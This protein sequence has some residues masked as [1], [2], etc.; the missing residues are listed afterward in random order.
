MEPVLIEACGLTIHAKNPMR[1]KKANKVNCDLIMLKDQE[2]MDDWEKRVRNRK[3]KRVLEVGINK[4]GSIPYIFD[5]LQA[6]FIVGVDIIEPVPG[7][8]KK[9]DGSRLN[10]KYALYFDTDQTDRAALNGICERHFKAGLDL[11]IDDASHLLHHTR[12]SFEI[13]FPKLRPGGL[14][15]IEDYVWAH[16]AG[17][18]MLAPKRYKGHPT[19]VQVLFEIAMLYSTKRDWIRKIIMDSNTITIIRGSGKIREPMNMRRETVNW[20]GYD[21]KT[22]EDSFTGNRKEEILGPDPD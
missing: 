1:E 11:V 21:F 19:M 22:L 3:V 9:L 16:N 12:E 7:L 6:D 8:F 17:F 10:G 13:L 18:G 14:Y 15:V 20:A 2:K 5:L 4:G